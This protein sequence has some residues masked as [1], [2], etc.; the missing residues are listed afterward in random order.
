MPT[1]LST[2]YARDAKRPKQQ[3]STTKPE[4]LVS[5]CALTS[6]LLRFVVLAMMKSTAIQK[7]LGNKAGLL[8]H[9]MLF[10]VWIKLSSK[11]R[12][13][14]LNK[15]IPNLPLARFYIAIVVHGIDPAKLQGLIPFPCFG[16]VPR[17]GPW[18]GDTTDSN[19]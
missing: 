3:T 11:V 5:G 15:G 12:L 13:I 1:W 6:T 7:Q 19:K 4:G 9:F 10:R 16:E 2:Q 14:L 8:I 18:I 17:V